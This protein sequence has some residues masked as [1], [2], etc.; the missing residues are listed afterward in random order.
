MRRGIP[1]LGVLA[2][3]VAACGGDSPAASDDPAEAAADTTA[4]S[5]GDSGEFT[6]DDPPEG[7]FFRGEATLTI[8]DQV[9]TFDNY[10]CFRGVENTQNDSVPFSSGAFGEV[11]GNRAQLDATVHDPSE[12]D[13]MEGDGV[14]G[15]VS[16]NDVDDFENPV[17]SWTGGG[18]LSDSTVFEFDGRTVFVETTFDD[19]LTD[20]LDEIPGTL[21]ATCGE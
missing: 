7:E 5:D 1:L 14:S 10:Y 16:L 4:A 12:E 15:S 18:A 2:L 3:V 9:Y 17:V 19:G 21:E 6:F 11:D 8:V 13:R 20:G